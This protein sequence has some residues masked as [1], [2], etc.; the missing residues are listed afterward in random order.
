MVNVTY[1]YG[2]VILKQGQVPTAC[3]MIETGLCRVMM[4]SQGERLQLPPSLELHAKAAQQGRKATKAQ[5]SLLENFNPDNSALRQINFMQRR[6]QN[7]RICID[8]NGNEVKNRV[9]YEDQ[10]DFKVLKPGDTFG[11]RTL[12]PYE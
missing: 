5:D 8:Q 2:E 9:L 3:Y 7:A 1:K 4:E 12:L 10:L 11:G 6:Y